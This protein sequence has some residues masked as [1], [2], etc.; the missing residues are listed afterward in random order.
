MDTQPVHTLSQVI[1]NNVILDLHP[2]LFTYI[3]IKLLVDLSS[4]HPI[5]QTFWAKQIT[6]NYIQNITGLKKQ[7]NISP[8]D[9]KVDLCIRNMYCLDFKAEQACIIK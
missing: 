8:L 7:L 6:T 5:F 4:Y 3:H 9:Y 2:F 1:N